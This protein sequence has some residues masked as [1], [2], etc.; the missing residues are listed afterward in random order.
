[1]KKIL[2]EIKFLFC[3]WV[4]KFI[5]RVYPYIINWSTK[6]GN[7]EMIN[8]MYDLSEEF[9]EIQDIQAQKLRNECVNLIMKISESLDA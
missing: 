2:E 7:L 5:L 6:E 1:M 8:I 3:L 9:R 4:F